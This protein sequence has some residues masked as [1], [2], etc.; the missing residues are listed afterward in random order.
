MSSEIK[1]L[2]YFYVFFSIGLT[3]LF[4]ISLILNIRKEYR[5]VKDFAKIEAEASYNKD[6]L[7]R[8]WATMHGGV[9]VPITDVTPTNPY[10]SFL[11]DRDITTDA[12]KKYTLINPAYMTRQVNALAE[13]QYGVKGHIT[14]LNPIRPENK[15]DEW[16]TKVLQKFEH[17]ISE[18][19]SIELLNGKEYLRYMHAMKVEENCLKCHASQG[20]KTGD[21][22]GGIS[23]SVPMDK[24]NKVLTSQIRGLIL[25]HFL[26]F[27]SILIFSIFGYKRLLVELVKRNLMQKKIAEN[28]LFLQQQ[29]KEYLSLNEEYKSQNEILNVAKEKAEE[30][31]RLKT[32]FLHN[33]SHEI[34]TPLNAIIGFSKMLDSR[35]LSSDKQNIFISIIEESSNQ[36]LS[37][38]NDILSISSLETK[39]EQ[40]RISVVNTN[41]IILD[42]LTMFNT[43]AIN[44]NISLYS[45]QPLTDKQSEIYTDKNKLTQILTHLLTNAFKFTH[46]GTI[47]FGYTLVET[48]SIAPPLIQFYVKDTGIG[49]NSEIQN[50][51]FESFRQAELEMNRKYGGTGLGL[52]ISKGF[53]ELLGGKIWVESSSDQGSTFYFTIPYKPAH[54][55]ERTKHESNPNE[56]LSTIL[57]AEDEIYNFIFIKEI[58]S[59]IGLTVLHTKEGNETVEFCKT[60][61]QLNLILMDIKMPVMD[62]FEA[63]KKI[64]EFRPDLPI[65]AQTAYALDHERE[66]YSG[67][68]FDDY[69][70]KPINKDELLLKIMKYLQANK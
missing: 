54:E 60:N 50:K 13:N 43:Q 70:T 24:Y 44:Q 17:G 49:I 15:A 41:N 16:E 6:L 56:I 66:K 46:E 22:R 68:A 2:K 62:G 40:I 20:Y 32:A 53:V 64:K 37:T 61:P 18:F 11:K 7:Y 23:V 31:E 25:T 63:A 30:S 1:Y 65:I 36:L 38:I 67:A 27:M 52:A 47:E 4:A 12:G 26:V 33:M 42:L 48:Q 3:I 28:E 29:N 57:V 34:R 35:D 58:L 9:Y 51:I 69:I 21:I 19:S 8:R 45:K 59:N 39:Q 5:S 14:S 10:L 55:I